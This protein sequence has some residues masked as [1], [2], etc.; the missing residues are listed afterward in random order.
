MSV[1]GS[2]PVTSTAGMA[3]YD[4]KFQISPIFLQGGIVGDSVVPISQFMSAFLGTDGQP[5]WRF[6][7]IPGATLISQAIGMYPFA[8]QQVAANATIQ[9]PLAV[10]MVLTAP[11]NQEGGYRSKQAAFMSLQNTLQ[12]HNSGGGWYTVATPAMLYQDILMVTMTDVT[13]Q[14]SRQHQIE[15]QFDFIAPIITSAQARAAEGG[16]IKKLSNGNQLPNPPTWT[17]P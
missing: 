14:D 9:Q 10:S 3:Q 8:T 11:V 2:G 6:Q 13:S 12:L 5:P 16:L 1:T 7:N 4:S 15:W 17:N